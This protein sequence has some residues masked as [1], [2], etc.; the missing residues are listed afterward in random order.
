ME[1][2]TYRVHLTVDISITAP[3]EDWDLVEI[4]LENNEL[5][6]ANHDLNVGW[7][8]ESIIESFVVD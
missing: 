2:R 4:D 1:T 8:E 3:E 5:W 7:I 6:D